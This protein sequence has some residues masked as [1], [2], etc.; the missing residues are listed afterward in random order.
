[1]LDRIRNSVDKR[2]GSVI[3]DANAS[4]AVELQLLY[5]ALND[6]M[7]ESFA[8]TASREFLIRRAR[9]RGITPFPAT[10][11]I[12][13]GEFTPVNIDVT[14]RRF[15]MPNT[16]LT[17]EVE[18]ALEENGQVLPGV[19][20]VLCEQVGSEGN[21][22]LGPII[23]ILH[24]S[25]LQTAEL[26]DILIPAQ[27]EEDTESIRQRY[28]DSFD[29]LGFGGNIRDYINKTNAIEGVGATKVT[30]VWNGGG[31][32]KLTILDN[33]FNA[34]SGGP[35]GLIEHVQEA[36]DPTQDHQ[37]MGIA[38][39]GHV[40]TVDTADEVPIYITADITLDGR[41][42]TAVENDV[43][44]GIESYL[45]ERR[46]DWANENS[47]NIILISQIN[48]RILSIAGVANVINI[49]INGQDTDLEL[50]RYEIPVFG[51]INV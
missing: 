27:D 8:D 9:E 44:E 35:G 45:L 48:S 10:H 6:I 42:W 32:V 46:R 26:T 3:Y 12:L 49:T 4:A 22:F 1:M 41:T 51:G 5:I 2:E 23:P 21:R 29:S 25:G 14:G 39:I 17:Y 18:A 30:P 24:I 47:V 16:P 43:K 38:P 31:T 19:Y 40:V 36:I 13:R 15:S 11:A 33:L 50:G 34:A 7:N 28:F 37:G 20:K